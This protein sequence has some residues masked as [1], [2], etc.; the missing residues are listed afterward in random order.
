MSQE[1]CSENNK[2]ARDI[3]VM[4]MYRSKTYHGLSLEK[5]FY[6]VNCKKKFVNTNEKARLNNRMIIPQGL[7]FKPCHPVH[8]DNARGM[9]LMQKP[10]NKNKTHNMF[11]KDHG[12]PSND[13]E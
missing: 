3:I 11:P 1:L 9:I 4:Y 2:L 13:L 6:D 10:W 12:N 7:N 8:Y 5:Y